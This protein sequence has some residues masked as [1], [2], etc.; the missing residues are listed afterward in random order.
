[1][2]FTEKDKQA[3][4]SAAADAQNDLLDVPDEALILVANWFRKWFP[5]AGYKRLGRVIVQ[6]AEKEGGA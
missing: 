3:M 5:K 4:D 1:M 2:A 6:Y